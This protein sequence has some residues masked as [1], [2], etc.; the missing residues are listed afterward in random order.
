MSG[1][2]SSSGVD[3]ISEQRA[4]NIT[5]SP[6]AR[7]LPGGGTQSGYRV[8]LMRATTGT[9]LLVAF[10]AAMSPSASASAPVRLAC[11]PGGGKGVALRAPVTCTVLPPRASF[12]EGVNLARLRWSD[13]GRSSATASGTER[14]F[15][16]PYSNIPVRIVAYRLRKYPCS[17]AFFYTRVRATSRS[18]HHHRRPAKWLS[19]PLNPD[20]VTTLPKRSGQGQS[21]L[22]GLAPL[23]RSCPFAG[24]TVPT[25][26]ARCDPA[27]PSK[28]S[29][30]PKVTGSNP[31]GRAGGFPAADRF[32][33]ASK[34][35]CGKAA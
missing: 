10:A 11:N 23:A 31:V 6:S 22:S 5:S 18:R 21:G 35:V 30:E 9:L 33:P 15:H 16:L 13:W 4:A 29:T 25:G 19:T 20:P 17:A 26:P 34:R 32:C 12:S 28:P 7:V 14:G 8:G 3:G 24:R 2:R 1:R 27:T